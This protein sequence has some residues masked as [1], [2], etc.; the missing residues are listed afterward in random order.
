[1]MLRRQL[2]SLGA[3]LLARA[4]KPARR[5]N[6]V[7][8]LADDQRADTIHALGNPHIHTPNLDRLAA[9]SA[10][11]QRAYCMGGNNPAVCLPS[12]NMILSG[13]A[14]TRYGQYAPASEPNFADAFRQAG[15]VTYHHGK[16][17]NS[18]QELQSRFDTCQYIDEKEARLSGQ[19]GKLIA[20]DAITFLDQRPKDRPFCLHLAFEAPHDPRVPSAEDRE[21]YDNAPIPM[22]PNFLPRHPFDNGE[23]TVRDELLAPWPRTE[24]EIR[25]HL[26]EYYATITGLDRQIGR[27]LTA[28][29]ERDL[30]KD[31]LVLFTSDQGLAVG[32]HG[33]MGKQNL[34]EHSMR[35]PLLMA[36]PGIEPGDRPALVYLM[37]IFPTLLDC[38][39]LRIPGGLDGFSFQHALRMP[40]ARARGGIFTAYRDCQR[41]WCDDRY[42][43]IVYP[44]LNRTQLFDLEED[45]HET[46][47]LSAAQ[48]QRVA[49]MMEQ[50]RAAQSRFGDPFALESLKPE[51][52]EWSPPTG[53]ALEALRKKWRM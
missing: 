10:V 25:R 46:K 9:R 41:A 20:D 33:L 13:R 6:I 52:G 43:L 7:F 19:P 31:T 37:D 45:P 39:G 5:P 23:M 1:M 29:A 53:E 40:L 36:G 22:P 12:R 14:Y 3:G 48:P 44:R 4:Q 24:E 32:S 28:L 11:F 51:S 26:R 27:I 34:Y 47:D 18:A 17:G 21:R 49:V 30:E 38:C 50:L 35:V 16:L 8:L 2:L 42:K 15:Y